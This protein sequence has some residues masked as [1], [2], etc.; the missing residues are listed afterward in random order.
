MKSKLFI[1]M[2]L[3][4]FLVGTVNAFEFDNVKSYNEET[5][6][7]T[8][9]NSILRIPFLE[10]D[11]VA[12]IQLNTPINYLVP[13]GYN[14]VA[15]FEIRVYEDYKNAF[16]ELELYDKRKG[17]NKF[18]RD[19]DFKYLT[20]ENI[21]VNDYISVCPDDFDET[22]PDMFTACEDVLSGSHLELR[23]KWIKLTPADFKKNDVLTIGIFTEVLKGDNVEW[24]P[25]FFGIRI[26]EWAGWEEN[27]NV[28]LIS[29]WKLDRVA[30][31]VLDSVG[32]GVNNG[33]NNGATTGV[34]GQINKSFDFETDNDDNVNVGSGTV[35]IA[36]SNMTINL[37]VNA[38]TLV[39]SGRMFATTTNGGYGLHITNT[40]QIGLSKFGISGV[41]STD[42]FSVS[43]W[44]MLS[45]TY[46]QSA[47]LV[48]FYFNGTV[49]S[50]GA[51]SYSATFDTG[52][53]YMIGD[54]SPIGNV[55]AFDGLMD[56]VFLANRTWSS[57]EIS[58]LFDAQK[59][60]FINGSF[61]PTDTAPTVTLNQPA[62]D[63]VVVIQTIIFN[64]TASDDT[65][66]INMTLYV[67]ESL[68]STNSSPIDSALTQFPHTF[69]STGLWNWT[70][71]ACDNIGK[72]TNATHRNVTF[73][74]NLTI[75]LNQP[76]NEFNSTSQ[77]IIFNATGSDDTDLVNMSFILNATYNGTNSSVFNNTLTQFSRTLAFGFYNWTVEVCDNNN[78]CLNATTRNFTITRFIENSQ[79][80]NA[81][82]F[83]TASET[84]IINITTNGTTPSSAKLIYNGTTFSGA[85]ITSTA[86]N[87]F[88]ISRT[89]NIPLVNG[90]KSFFFNITIGGTELSSSTQNQ[91]I[92]ST[93][94][95]ICGAAPQDT[96][97]INLT[98]RNETTAEENITATIVST[99]TYS[100]STISEINKTLTFSD[101]S[102]NLNY[103]FCSSASNRT[104][105]IELSMT[106]A[107]SISQQRSFTLTSTLTNLSATQVLY[108]LPTVSGLFS[109]FTTV[110][111]LGRAIENVKGTITR[112]LNGNPITVASGFTDGSGFISFF[113][114]PN[115]LYTGTFEKSGFLTVIETFFP[116]IDLRTVTM[117]SSLIVTNG[118]IISLNGTYQIT[119]TNTTLLNNTNITFG[120]NVTS[121]ESITLIS[122]N[123]TNT[124]GSQ[125]LFV[126]NAGT[127]FISGIVNTSTNTRLIGEFI[128]QT[129]DET[130]IISRTWIIFNFFPGDYSIFRQFTLFTTYEFSDF[131]RLLMVIITI[132]G[133]LIF[134]TA[135][136]VIDTSESKIIV[137]LL[138]I[139]AFS[140]VGW[141]D[142]NIVISSASNQL[143][144]LAQL[145]NQ[146]GIA[147][148]TTSAGLFFILRRIFV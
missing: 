122:M 7:I 69:T 29:Y 110:D 147:I 67:N 49:D 144:T 26:N 54:G 118:S 1:F 73:S 31:P 137:S 82:S 87:D 134:M 121:G 37:W 47:D 9:K 64:A 139:W 20:Y 71:E 86:G 141:L 92:N 93:D 111:V 145:S 138:L 66:L 2:F 119:P 136:E 148:L 108:L 35:N 5:K 4:I 116:V 36:T 96:P 19:F 107:N 130:Q 146:F 101:V 52:K 58:D 53:T 39:S 80:F 50:G 16:K 15:E 38:E 28:G 95:T 143:N 45:M 10:L 117:I 99:W 61:I 106:Y 17:N 103:T 79:T 27:W 124:T 113:L 13:R 115:I 127:G 40:G 68:I 77:T 98:F 131:I 18:V 126:S 129:D 62:N 57:S 140:I 112:T 88:N 91:I 42:T 128:I 63:A 11:T 120:F 85:T 24:I 90:T 43:E 75:T 41:L 109:Q 22:N 6:T 55:F 70:V 44:V 30:D 84:F 123:I 14:K 83:E 105:N 97:F 33:T 132:I 76:I 48:N 8:I 89:I 72:C 94:F 125:L 56:E 12:E 114:D 25:N 60:G 34:T 3:M 81:S 51:I 135:G 23:E 74:N 59:D 100:L 142:T 104:L 78:F 65:N 21:S 102:E 133:V 32:T 46:D